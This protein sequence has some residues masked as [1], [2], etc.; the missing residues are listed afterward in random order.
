MS[1]NYWNCTYN[2]VILYKTQVA[3]K[4]TQ[5]PPYQMPRNMWKCD[6]CSVTP[7]ASK[8]ESQVE[9]EV[10][11]VLRSSDSYT[12]HFCRLDPAWWLYVPSPLDECFRMWPVASASHLAHPYY[13]TDERWLFMEA[14]S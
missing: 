2:S 13:R 3:L 10:D 6:Y 8:T 4:Y 12:R 9:P 7:H 5:P 14:G 1:Y 11:T